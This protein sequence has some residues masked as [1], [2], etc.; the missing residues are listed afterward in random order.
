MN[1]APSQRRR[2]GYSATDSTPLR[3]SIGRWLLLSTLLIVVVSVA[4]LTKGNLPNTGNGPR[5]SFSH[6]ALA[7]ATGAASYDLVA[8][9]GGVF[10]YGGGAY[11]GSTGNI[12]LNAPIVGMASTPD[13]KG[14]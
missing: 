9:D 13:G 10:T 4:T 6:S 14:Y 12:K 1:Q 11:Y 5:S 3:R 2:R 8:A 7:S